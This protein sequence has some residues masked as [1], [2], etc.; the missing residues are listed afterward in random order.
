MDPITHV[1]SGL[2]AGQALRNR[3]PA[4]RWVLPF[5]ALFA[6]LPDVDILTSRLG[7]EA[8]LRLHRGLT[9]SIAGGAA[10]ALLGVALA[11]IFKVKISAGKAWLLAYAMLLLHDWLDVI[12]T[13][14][15]Q[16][17]QPFSN[18]RISLPAVFIIDPGFTL[19]LLALFVTSLFWKRR[20]AALGLAGVVILFAYPLAS[21]GI[22]QA[23]A[24]HEARA[25]R[26]GGEPV[27][28]VTAHPDAFAP[29]YWKIVADLGD[30][31]EMRGVDL[32]DPSWAPEPQRFVK[33]DRAQMRAFGRT[34][35][36]F[37]TYEW[38]ARFPY[39]VGGGPDAEGNL[40]YGD[41]RFLSIN[42]LVAKVRNGGPSFALKAVLDG[43]GDLVRAIW[44][45]HGKDVIFNPEG[46]APP[47][48]ARAM[49][50]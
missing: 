25:L 42:P 38:F 18:A 41:V 5:T 23:V 29:I 43:H 22:G 47:P 28:A 10:L 32:L 8:S 40:T 19:A 9:H 3:L 24:A 14:G 6:W 44:G 48:H 45:R 39:L 13:Y 49:T 26:A 11:R 4:G 1:A 2:V 21:F 12:T 7:V 50:P 27:V 33:A 46:P 15:T 35:P 37:A 20:R 31:W 36:V 17:L 34:I 16:I 30:R